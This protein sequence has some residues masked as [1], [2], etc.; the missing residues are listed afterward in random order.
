M[1]IPQGPSVCW[2]VSHVPFRRSITVSPGGYGRQEAIAEAEVTVLMDLAAQYVTRR[3]PFGLRIEGAPEGAPADTPRAL[4]VQGTEATYVD[5]S[6]IDGAP[7]LDPKSPETYP[8][9]RGVNTPADH[10]CGRCS[11]SPLPRRPPER[12]LKRE[13][14][15]P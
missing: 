2:V 11:L 9:D 8:S 14:T 15:S 4:P 12:A 6:P 13:G 3:F 5:V 7:T 1:G 10:W